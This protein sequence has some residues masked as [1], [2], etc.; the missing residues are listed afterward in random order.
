VGV[1]GS[2][3]VSPILA[4]GVVG[5]IYVTTLMTLSPTVFWSPDE[6]AKF[7]QM[8]NRLADAAAPH[9][10]AYGA[11]QP[12][13][14]TPSIRPRGFIRGPCGPRASTT[15]G[16]IASRSSRFRSTGSSVLG[17]LCHPARGGLVATAA[18]AGLVRRLDPDAETPAILLA[19]LCAP[20]FFLS[21]LFFEHTLAGALGIGAL[22][23]GWNLWSGSVR[24][25]FAWALAAAACLRDCSRFAAKP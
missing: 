4:L 7:I 8:H 12:I 3:F 20:L 10:L 6:G 23:C 1:D 25:R 19:G 22:S 11:P 13:R 5:A 14:L 15:I 2:A 17:A 24:R 16:P 21:V 18:V 9:R